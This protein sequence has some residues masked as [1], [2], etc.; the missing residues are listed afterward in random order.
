MVFHRQA[1]IFLFIGLFY[2]IEREISSA[3]DAACH[4]LFRIPSI[5][6]N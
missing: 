5:D 2:V 4:E 3:R 6:E 1:P